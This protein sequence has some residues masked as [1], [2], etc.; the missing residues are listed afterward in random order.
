MNNK[1]FTFFVCIS[2]I[3]PSFLCAEN[4]EYAPYLNPPSRQS[5]SFIT[6]DPVLGRIFGVQGTGADIKHY[7]FDVSNRT[8][9][10]AALRSALVPGWGQHFNNEKGKALLFFV[11]TV[12]L[13]AGS[14]I[15][16]S[17]S[18]HT[19]NEYKESGSR[20]SVLF[21]DY[22]DERTQALAMGVTALVLYTFG[23]IDAH[24]RAYAPLYSSDRSL[25]LALS[26]SESYLVWSRKF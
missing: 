3:A 15:R 24:R 17:D 13:A 6:R 23:I 12:G 2:L 8:P 4:D 14:L 22:E 21:D 7:V 1:L 5:E 9:R 20:N 11:T 25:Q 19:Y 10:H 26:P 16:Y 18:R